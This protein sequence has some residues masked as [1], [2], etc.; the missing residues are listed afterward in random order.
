MALGDC[1]GEEGLSSS[2]TTGH[3]YKK[4]DCRLE[5]KRTIK[6]AVHRVAESS[7]RRFCSEL[8]C[9]SDTKGIRAVLRFP[10]S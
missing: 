8:L 1:R 2:K 4:E 9:E 7:A 3:L 6:K 5:R 10:L